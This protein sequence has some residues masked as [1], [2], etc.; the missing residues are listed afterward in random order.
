MPGG[1]DSYLF[2]HRIPPAR[3][4]DAFEQAGQ[5][6]PEFRRQVGEVAAPVHQL[7][8]LVAVVLQEALAQP[9]QAL[10]ALA[11]QVGGD[12]L[13]ARVIAVGEQPGAEL[14]LAAAHAQQ[15]V[16]VTL[17]ANLLVERQ[18]AVEQRVGAGG[19]G[20]ER[21]LDQ[22]GDVIGG[23]FQEER[24]AHLVGD[25][26][27]LAQKPGHGHGAGGVV[28]P[29]PVLAH[30]PVLVH[31]EVGRARIASVDAG[32]QIAVQSVHAQGQQLGPLAAEA[33]GQLLG[34]DADQVGDVAGVAGPLP[35]Q[36][37]VA[38]EHLALQPDALTAHVRQGVSAQCHEVRVAS[39]AAGHLEP[40]LRQAVPHLLVVHQQPGHGIHRRHGDAAIALGN[41]AARHVLELVDG[42]LH[43]LLAALDVALVHP[44]HL[45][46]GIAADALDDGQR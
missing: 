11:R 28:V 20:V 22:L 23:R 32:A 44:Q 39:D 46:I 35:H 15:A 4:A 18:Q 3:G 42:L 45:A 10:G 9:L 5:E 12:T 43:P 38:A 40:G 2:R 7:P 34:V 14:D 21:H 36:R 31:Q 26:A 19:A 1:F 16:L 33:A 6:W 41:G 30:Q 29:Q 8:E 27:V 37:Q 24:D 25:L 17:L 13:G